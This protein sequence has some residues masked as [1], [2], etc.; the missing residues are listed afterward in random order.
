MKAAKNVLF[1]P[2][3]MSGL[4]RPAA[5]SV[6]II[7]LLVLQLSQ[8]AAAKKEAHNLDSLQGAKVG[9]FKMLSRYLC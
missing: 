9:G 8:K 3:F 7:S 2:S 6:F 4:R 1:L 5:F